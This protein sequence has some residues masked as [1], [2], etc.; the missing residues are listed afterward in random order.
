[1]TAAA[2][3]GDVPAIDCRLG[4]ARRQDRSQVVVSGVTIDA[5]RC[6][7]SVL[8]RLSVEAMIVASVDLGM[9]KSATEIRKRLAA[10]VTT[11]ALQDR[12]IF[13]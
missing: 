5:G 10:T 12:I 3:V 7:G 1:M 13:R 9:E 4:I 2:G 11:L 6:F 8:N